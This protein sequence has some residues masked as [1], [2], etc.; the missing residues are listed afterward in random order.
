MTERA[1]SVTDSRATMAEASPRAGPTLRPRLRPRPAYSFFYE[2]VKE[3]LCFECLKEM[4]EARVP[5]DGKIDPRSICLPSGFA[6]VEEGMLGEPC[7]VAD[8]SAKQCRLYLSE[9]RKLP[10]HKIPKVGMRADGMIAIRNCAARQAKMERE[11]EKILATPEL[12]RI[13]DKNVRERAK[14][15]WKEAQDFNTPI[16]AEC[17]AAAAKDTI[18]VQ[19]AMREYYT[20]VHCA[21]AQQKECRGRSCICPCYF[22]GVDRVHAMAGSRC[23]CSKPHRQA[24]RWCGATVAAP[25]PKISENKKIEIDVYQTFDLDFDE[26]S[27]DQES[28]KQLKLEDKD[29]DHEKK[30]PLEFMDTTNHRE[31]P[32]RTCVCEA[33]RLCEVIGCDCFCTYCLRYKAKLVNESSATDQMYCPC[34]NSDTCMGAETCSCACYKCAT[35]KTLMGYCPFQPPIGLR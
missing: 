19:K 11:E 18:A 34:W 5:D 13:L 15:A 10:R 8:E 12:S 17:D 31:Q 21:C 9:H 26:P 20:S 27:V 14:A 7:P 30:P 23:K 3:D 29:R 16:R 35:E 28:T 25:A 33:R 24:K 2:R 4:S 32:S 22:C 1:P 6:T